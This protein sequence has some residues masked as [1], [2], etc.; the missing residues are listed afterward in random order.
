MGNLTSRSRCA[1][2]EPRKH[3]RRRST[4]WRRPLAREI[5]IVLVFKVVALTTIKLV[6]FS[7]PLDRTLD[8]SGVAEA[9]VAPDTPIGKMTYD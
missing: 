1:G 4:L 5:L 3:G 7:D 9:F 8:G 2:A 6:F